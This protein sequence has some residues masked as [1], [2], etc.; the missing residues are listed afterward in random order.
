M[1][2]G[3]HHDG[4]K[5]WARTQ[6]TQWWSAEMLL[7][8]EI[9]IAFWWRNYSRNSVPPVVSSKLSKQWR[10]NDYLQQKRILVECSNNA[11][12]GFG[13]RNESKMQQWG[14]DFRPQCWYWDQ[15]QAARGG[16]RN[17]DWKIQP[18]WNCERNRAKPTRARWKRIA[19][20]RVSKYWMMLCFFKRKRVV[21]KIWITA[22]GILVFTL[23]KPGVVKVQK[24]MLQ[25]IKLKVS[26]LKRY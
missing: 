7:T 23:T 5:I 19:G 10:R 25:H 8:L 12:Q 24:Q 6:E 4:Q 26:L 18:K 20:E 17:E 15:W 22:S 1:G 21:S 9:S 11:K 14:L 2:F 16:E 13:K 3:S